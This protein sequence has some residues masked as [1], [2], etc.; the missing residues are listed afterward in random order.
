MDSPLLD[1]PI[2]RRQVWLML[3]RAMVTA[4]VIIVCG[5]YLIPDFLAAILTPVALCWSLTRPLKGIGNTVAAIGLAIVAVAGTAMTALGILLL[6]N[7]VGPFWSIF[8][9]G[10]CAWLLTPVLVRVAATLWCRRIQ[11]PSLR[12][13]TGFGF[14]ALA[15]ILQGL[16]VFDWRD[17]VGNGDP[18]I[19][20]ATGRMGIV[21]PA[22]GIQSRFVC[23]PRGPH[24]LWS[25]DYA[26]NEWLYGLFRPHINAWFWL[27]RNCY[28]DLGP[29]D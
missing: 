20:D 16:L 10:W 14:V 2:K 27:Y 17:A 3:T 21:Y 6:F 1:A 22:P 4:A 26:G 8:L 7:R 5:W 11:N 15:Y 13:R 24:F 9:Q 19:Y 29:L 25:V 12:V 18:E 23:F 28:F